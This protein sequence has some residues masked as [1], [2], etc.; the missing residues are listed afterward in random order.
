[1]TILGGLVIAIFVWK[2]YKPEGWELPEFMYRAGTAEDLPDDPVDLGSSLFGISFSVSRIEMRE[3]EDIER[4]REFMRNMR[5]ESSSTERK[6]TL[7]RRPRYPFY[8]DRKIQLT[9][10]ILAVS[11]IIFLAL[12][13]LLIELS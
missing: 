3:P 1:L 8:Q 12:W 2:R 6:E 4:Y 13:L 7:M 9:F 5:G 11:I 10:P